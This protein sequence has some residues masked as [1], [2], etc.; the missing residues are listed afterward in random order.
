MANFNTSKLGLALNL[1]QPRGRELARR[2]V[3]WA[4]VV[5]ESFT[6]GTM[7]RFGLDW[8]TLSRERED[9]VMLTH[10]CEDRP[11]LSARTGASG[12]RARP[13]PASIT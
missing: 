10:A 2:L 11:V 7:A 5:V 8:A 4:D 1:E 12:T 9:L 13:S 3:D 6:P